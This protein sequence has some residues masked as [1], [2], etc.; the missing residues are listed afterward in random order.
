MAG[1]KLAYSIF[2]LDNFH[3]LL[4]L[5]LAGIFFY[6]GSI[7]IAHPESFAL[8]IYNYKV[9]P[10]ALVN[11]SALILPFLEILCALGLL[12]R[13]SAKA[14]N[15][16][17]VLIMLVFLIASIQAWLRGLNIQCGCFGKG[18]TTVGPITF[19]RDSAIVLGLFINEFLISMKQQAMQ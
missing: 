13:F 15:H 17:L 1:K 14:S 3:W 2:T 10:L 8:D 9:L 5:A 12:F 19:L 16:F 11:L 4:K 6:A 7:K 18:S